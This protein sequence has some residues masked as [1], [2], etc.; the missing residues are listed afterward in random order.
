MYSE[1][2]RRE[3]HRQA[4]LKKVLSSQEE[5]RKRLAR[6]LHDDAGQMLTGLL[7]G[8]DGI[9]MSIP[10]RPAAA[11]RQVERMRAL[12]EEMLGN[13]RSMVL[14]LR[15]P[16]LDDIG[17]VPAIERY[18]ETAIRQRG[19]EFEIDSSLG[20]DRLAPDWEVAIFRIVQE[21][22]NN[23]RHH[24]KATE[25]VVTLKFAPRSLGITVRDNGR[26][27]ALNEMIGN[28]AA[29]GKLGLIGMQQRAKLLDGTYDIRSQ[30]GEGT[31]VSVKIT[32]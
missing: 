9:A 27:F 29:E 8:L 23:I 5:E 16:V 24:S 17:L 7:M 13:L 4:L 3:A 20:A 6:E 1:S 19:I 32:D 26:G 12:S 30:P 25:A 18:A 10:E 15:P 11:L 22:L 2:L 14:A 21:A 31:L 28:L